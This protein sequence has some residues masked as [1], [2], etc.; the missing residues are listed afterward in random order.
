MTRLALIAG[1][2]AAGALA[3]LGVG[4]LVGWRSFPLAT[5]LVNLAGSF[6]LGVLLTWGVTRVSRDVGS[7]LA[8]G[9]LGA[10]TTFSTFAVDAKLL[11][12]DGRVAAAALYVALT[13]A[14]GLAAAITGVL[15]GRALAAH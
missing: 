1:F 7:G 14:L 8:I 6:A 9:F 10:F 2:G 13:M 4:N 15:V 12:D 11:A 3:R 5:L